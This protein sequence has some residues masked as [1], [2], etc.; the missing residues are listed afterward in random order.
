LLDGLERDQREHIGS[1]LVE[2]AVAERL[3]SHDARFAFEVPTHAGRTADFLVHFQGSAFHLHVKRWRPPPEDRPVRLKVPPRL[4]ELER[5]RRPFL[6]GVRWP[7]GPRLLSR[8]VSEATSFLRQASV[9]DE[10]VVRADPDDPASAIAG[11]V[12]VLAPWPGERVVLTL[13]LDAALDDES[14]TLKRL[15]RKACAQFMPGASNVIAICGGAS[16]ADDARDGGHFRIIDQALL[17]THVE[18]WDLFPPR[19]QHVAH[20]RGD[21]GFWSGGRFPQSRVVV[22]CPFDASN[23]LGPPRL[24]TRG[25]GEADAALAGLA[26]RSLT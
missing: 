2:A 11:G 7:S 25:D 5:V 3:L 8:F 19:G 1:P 18:R 24:W 13:G 10:L 6:V 26:T 16:A 17:G 12:R 15:L 14:R 20:G 22:W 4:R 9:G 21:D 23:G